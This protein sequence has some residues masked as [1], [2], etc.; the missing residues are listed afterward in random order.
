MIETPHKRALVAISGG[1][2]S[3][4]VAGLIQN[5]FAQVE[6]V[7]FAFEDARKSLAQI[8]AGHFDLTLSVVDVREE[9]EAKVVEACAIRQRLGL[10]AEV[11]R[12]FDEEILFP[13]LF[14]IARKRNFDVIFTG[15]HATS[16]LS[17]DGRIFRLMLPDEGVSPE[18]TSLAGLPVEQLKLLRT[19]M[20]GLSQEKLR[21]LAQEF[22]LLVVIPEA[23]EWR[24]KLP[25][26]AFNVRD[27][28]LRDVRFLSFRSPSGV[29]RGKAIL[30]PARMLECEIIRM[31]D[32]EGQVRFYGTERLELGQRLVLLQEREVIG[33]GEV[34]KALDPKNTL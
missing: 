11:G 7:H 29:W 18:T 8:V 20:A 27:Y 34:W 25:G 2:S 24:F 15:H 23:R 28:L 22:G 1:L 26:E 13:R 4:V 19:P 3:A 33:A 5:E 12:L 30:E 16:S 10:A 14:E 17:A 31:A 9:F 6:L 21:T 32:G